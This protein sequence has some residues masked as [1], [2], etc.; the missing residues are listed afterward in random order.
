M[1]WIELQRDLIMMVR[2]HPSQPA[3]SKDSA[4]DLARTI[5]DGV[6]AMVTEG[7]T[8][9]ADLEEARR[10]LRR[11]LAEMDRERQDLG[12]SVFTESTLAGAMARLCP[13]FWPFC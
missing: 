3:F 9:D 8:G 11:L 10:N 2:V 6:A 1:D 4:M 13:G 5:A 12:L 7:R